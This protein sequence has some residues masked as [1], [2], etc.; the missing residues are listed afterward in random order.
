[1][2]LLGSGCWDAISRHRLR[3]RLRLMLAAV[4]DGDH[5]KRSQAAQGDDRRSWSSQ[6]WAPSRPQVQTSCELCW[7]L[8]DLV[9]GPGGMGNPGT[10][11]RGLFV[12]AVP[13]YWGAKQLLP[14][15]VRV[16]PVQWGAQWQGCLAGSPMPGGSRAPGKHLTLVSA[17][18]LTPRT[19]CVNWVPCCG[20]CKHWKLCTQ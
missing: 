7:S 17:S 15:V 14:L 20:V 13:G 5:A 2:L 3:L 4:G 19:Q 16:V 8:V 12:R 1:M 10:K 9:P 11:R 18:L 6:K